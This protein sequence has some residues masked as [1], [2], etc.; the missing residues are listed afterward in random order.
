[1][2]AELFDERVAF[3]SEEFL[4]LVDAA[5]LHEQEAELEAGV[6]DA[7][8]HLH[9]S[10]LHIEGKQIDHAGGLG[11]EQDGLEGARGSMND[12]VALMGGDVLVASSG[13][14]FGIRA[15]CGDS[16]RSGHEV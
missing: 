2:K 9:F 12:D 15:I 16:G 5:A 1:M 7:L 11:L 4:E 6:V 13:L 10:A 3:G 8:E 14:R